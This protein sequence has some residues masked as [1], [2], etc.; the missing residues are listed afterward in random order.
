MFITKFLALHRANSTKGFPLSFFYIAPPLVNNDERDNKAAAFLLTD[1]KTSTSLLP[2]PVVSRK[3]DTRAQARQKRN[4]GAHYANDK[5]SIIPSNNRVVKGSFVCLPLPSLNVNNPR[6][7]CAALLEYAE[8]CFVFFHALLLKRKL[9]IR[10]WTRKDGR[11]RASLPKCQC[12]GLDRSITK[13][14]CSHVT[15]IFIVTNFLTWSLSI[16]FTCV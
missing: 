11:V 10:Y 7:V 12:K 13:A 2:T 16:I 3:K 1:F 15:S 6:K 8:R 5:P 9:K 4:S 14:A